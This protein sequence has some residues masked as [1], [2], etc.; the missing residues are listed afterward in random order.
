VDNIFGVS[1]S[2]CGSETW[3]TLPTSTRRQS[4][5]AD[6][7][8]LINHCES[9]KAVKKIWTEKG[10]AIKYEER[11]DKEKGNNYVWKAK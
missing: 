5:R 11:R 4:Q 1:E 10:E 8:S 9:L 6:L 7:T 3:T 2:S